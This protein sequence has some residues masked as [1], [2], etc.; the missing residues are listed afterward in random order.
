MCKRLRIMIRKV[1]ILFVFL[2]V[3]GTDG[4]SVNGPKI[5]YPSKHHLTVLDPVFSWKFKNS[6]NIQYELMIAEDQEYKKNVIKLRTSLSQLHLTLPYLKK[7][8]VYFWTVRAIYSTGLKN[9]ETEWAHDKKKD[10]TI[11]Q[12]TVGENATGYV[13]YEPVIKKPTVKGF[14]S[15]LKPELRWLYPKHSEGLFE[16]YNSKGIWI[17]P[18][19]EEI[20]YQLQISRNPGFNSIIKTFQV[21]GDSSVLKLSIPWLEAGATYYWRVKAIYKDPASDKETESGWSVAT[22]GA[23]SPASF[24]ITPDA[25]GLFGFEEGQKE[26][27]F[28]PYKLSSVTPLITGT[29]NYFAPSVSLDGTRLAFCS[30]RDGQIEVYIKNLADG[31]GGGETR[32]T[33]SQTGVVNFSPFWLSNNAEIGFYSNRFKDENRWAVYSSTRGTGTSATFQTQNMEFEEKADMFNLYGSSSADDKI[34]FTGKFRNGNSYIYTLLLKDMKD[35]SITSLCPGL[36]PCI[37]N[38]DRI[39]YI[40]TKDYRVM[41]LEIEGNSLKSLRNITQDKSVNFD[42]VFS[43]DG[44]RIAFAS[45]RSGNT[46]IWIINSDGSDLHQV[47]FHPMVDRRP[48]WIDNENI[49]FQTNREKFWSIYKMSV[50][51]N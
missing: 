32:K 41:V 21:E 25:E 26:E 31:F 44:S 14:I 38:D 22:P 40:D 8:G 1:L 33:V 9:I 20:K 11:F 27:T 13:G 19:I 4:Y 3:T 23:D 46:D 24:N 16:V 12:F 47:T 50:P 7:G 48:Q 30:D 10:R 36:F 15:T 6:A 43:P 18:K 42:P 29:Y 34:V 45:T 51:K 28:D 37:S 17:S 2:T 39:V 35:N 5:L 49:V